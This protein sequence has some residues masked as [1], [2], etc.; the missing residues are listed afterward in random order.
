MGLIKFFLYPV[1]FTG[2]CTYFAFSLGAKLPVASRE[3]GRAIGMGFNYF[4]VMLRVLTPAADE[5]NAIVSQ[6]R[7]GSQ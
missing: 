7:Q 3:A 5:A 2:S 1:F 4:K 6:Y